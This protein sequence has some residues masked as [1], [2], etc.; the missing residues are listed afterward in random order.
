MFHIASSRFRNICIYMYIYDGS[1]A[2]TN[3]AALFTWRFLQKPHIYAVPSQFP[4][5]CMCVCV[6]CIHNVFVICMARDFNI[7]NQTI[8]QPTYVVHVCAVCMCLWVDIIYGGNSALYTFYGGK[9]FGQLCLK[10]PPAR[11]LFI[12]LSIL[13]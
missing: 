5:I 13:L 3:I 11:K 8:C 6:C 9:I 2:P 4:V 10:L 12:H 1:G 7:N